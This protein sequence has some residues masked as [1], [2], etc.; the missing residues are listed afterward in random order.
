MW[1]L[2]TRFGRDRVQHSVPAWLL[3]AAATYDTIRYVDQ[4]VA[5]LHRDPSRYAYDPAARYTV[6]IQT[7]DTAWHNMR[8][9]AFGRRQIGE[10]LVELIPDPYF[11]G[12]KG[13]AQLR[14]AAT[15]V[16]P[17]HAREPLVGWRGSVT[18]AAAPSIEMIPRVALALACRDIPG[19]DV[20]LFGVHPT[21]DNSFEPGTIAAFLARHD[22]EGDRW[23]MPA[24]AGYRYVLDI[25]GHANAWGF[26]EKLILGCCVLKVGSVF[27]Q[28][29]YD[30]LQPWVHYV[31]VRG[32]LSDL[33]E[34]I[35]WCYAHDEQCAW[36]AG[37]AARAAAAMR[38]DDEV[39]RSCRAL[40]WATRA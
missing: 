27:E 23:Y 9:L 31:P 20:R 36:I 10:T 5:E 4:L 16:P 26:I 17:W 7:W 33:R 6:F 39:P 32:D 38:F 24:F 21:M 37:N 30:R 22:L 19:T 28:W 18:G 34:V 1:G 11:I 8:S 2:T 35:D 3:N 40:R 29:F 15:A 14:I 13:Y 25:D 12:H